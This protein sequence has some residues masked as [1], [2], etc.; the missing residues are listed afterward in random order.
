METESRLFV[1]IIP[2]FL[3]FV[4]IFAAGYR[5]LITKN[6]AVLKYCI[7]SIFAATLMIA[8]QVSWSWTYFIKNDLLGTEIA[9]LMWTA[10]N[11]LVMIKIIYA[12][13]KVEPKK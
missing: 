4:A 11:S 10:F 8:A 13:R 3:A 7:M 1:E 5:A 2:L 6:P 12:A 9:N